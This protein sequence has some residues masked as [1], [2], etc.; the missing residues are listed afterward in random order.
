VAGAPNAQA[1]DNAAHNLQELTTQ[2]LD[3]ADTIANQPGNSAS[4]AQIKVSS[5]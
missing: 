2:L 3:D 4:K 1:R 5:L